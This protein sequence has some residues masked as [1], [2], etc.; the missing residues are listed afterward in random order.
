M[1]THERDTQ[2]CLAIEDDNSALACL[3][4]IVAQY[5]GSDVCRPKLVLLTQE[6]CVPCKEEAALHADDIAKGVI[7]KIDVDSPEGL[8]I[9]VKNDISLIPSLILLDC[10]D[11]LIM[12]TV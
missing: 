9:A 6:G 7:Q 4:K 2:D 8:A 11:N 12:P 5:S 10:H 3:K 1:E